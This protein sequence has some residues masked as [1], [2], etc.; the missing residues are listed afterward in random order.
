VFISGRFNSILGLCVT[1]LFLAIITAEDI[2]K[3]K[4]LR[5]KV[6]HLAAWTSE[7]KRWDWQAAAAALGLG[8]ELPTFSLIYSSPRKKNR[9][10]NCKCSDKYFCELTASQSRMN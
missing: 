1:I 6:Q 8:W 5:D 7:D 10:S 2:S 9:S 3:R 4:I